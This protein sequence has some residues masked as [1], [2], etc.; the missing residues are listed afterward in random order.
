[1][2]ALPPLHKREHGNFLKRS[3]HSAKNAK[4]PRRLPALAD[5]PKLLSD[6]RGHC[7]AHEAM[8][9]CDCCPEIAGNPQLRTIICPRQR[10]GRDQGISN[11]PKP[12]GCTRSG[13]QSDFR[14]GEDRLPQSG[15]PGEVWGL[16][17]P[18]V[19]RPC[20]VRNW[21][22]AVMRSELSSRQ[23]IGTRYICKLHL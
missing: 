7:G 13:R 8:R 19:H 9:S 14:P 20:A 17:G 23:P 22:S 18:S 1:M 15:A 4:G 5:V 3:P 21:R 10:L 12:R 6:S 11:R 16:S 2:A